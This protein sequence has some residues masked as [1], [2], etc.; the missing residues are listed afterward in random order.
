M[1]H[2]KHFNTIIIMA[3]QRHNAQMDFSSVPSINLPRSSFDRTHS[4]KTTFNSGYL[5]PMFVDEVLPGDT[6]KLDMVA[7]ARLNTPLKPFMDNLYLNSFFFFVPNIFPII[8]PTLSIGLILL[9]AS[10][11]DLL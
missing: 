9:V 2:V 10:S 8:L 4:Y 6:M 5:I 3:L 7:F 11:K 1:F